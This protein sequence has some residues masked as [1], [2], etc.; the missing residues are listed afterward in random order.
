MV[1][2]LAFYSDN[3]GSNPAKV[4]I[5]FVKFVYEKTKL[6]KKGPGL[7]PFLKMVLF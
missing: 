1:S 3:P 7:G 4:C 2:V 6:N 5:F